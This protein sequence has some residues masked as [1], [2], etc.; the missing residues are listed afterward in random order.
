MLA[1]DIPFTFKYLFFEKW[2]TGICID[3]DPT[4]YKILKKEE[5]KRGLLFLPIAGEISFSSVLSSELS[6]WQRQ[7]IDENILFKKPIQVRGVETWNFIK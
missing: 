1:P 6:R 2:L 5:S 7:R 4:Q 3:A